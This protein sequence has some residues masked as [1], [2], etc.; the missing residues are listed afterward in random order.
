MLNIILPILF[1]LT[2][3]LPTHDY[4]TSLTMVVF[5]DETQLTEIQM[6]FE[7]EHLEYVLNKAFTTDVHL[8]EA[9]ETSTCD[10][11]LMAYVNKH[12]NLSINNKKEY[13]LALD[14]KEVDYAMTILKFKPIKTKRKWKLIKL[15][16]TLL[17]QYFPRQEHLVHFF[18]KDEKESML[19]NSGEV[20][21][22]IRF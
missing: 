22:E 9:N 21:Q 10:S 13:E 4:H 16:N 6:Q 5:N 17:Y 12:F 11:L 8:G 1:G 18:Y 19:F 15:S 3:F 14:R 7:T 2:S 20:R